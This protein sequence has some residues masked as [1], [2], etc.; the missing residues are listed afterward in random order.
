MHHPDSV[1]LLM[2]LRCDY[3]KL[4]NALAPMLEPRWYTYDPEALCLVQHADRSSA[5]QH[6]EAV[7][8]ANPNQLVQI[9]V[10]D[11]IV[12]MLSRWM[13]AVPGGQANSFANGVKRL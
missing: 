4:S 8:R 10:L 1:N 11:G 5:L 7:I 3:H 9:L 2:V 12:S 13:A 6:A